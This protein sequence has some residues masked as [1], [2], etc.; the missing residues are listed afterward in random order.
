VVNAS[1]RYRKEVKVEGN[2]GSIEW[3]PLGNY[4]AA[5]R[6]NEVGTRRVYVI[7]VEVEGIKEHFELDDSTNSNFLSFS[8]GENWL[9]VGLDSD[10]GTKCRLFNLGEYTHVDFEMKGE[11]SA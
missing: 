10:T 1:K 3:S 5:I 6:T 9:V 8:P 2:F 4:C 7:A 11:T